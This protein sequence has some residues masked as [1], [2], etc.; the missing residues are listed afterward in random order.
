MGL[1][2]NQLVHQRKK[3]PFREIPR[4]FISLGEIH[5]HSGYQWIVLRVVYRNSLFF[6]GILSKVDCHVYQYHMYYVYGHIVHECVYGTIGLV[7]SST[8]VR[9]FFLSI[10]MVL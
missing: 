5:F 2:R 1:D 4:F 6:T 3:S 8:V 10:Q 9:N 7:V